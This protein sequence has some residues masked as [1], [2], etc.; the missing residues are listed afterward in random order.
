MQQI[1]LDTWSGKTCP[2]PSQ[3]TT[4]KD[5]RASPRRNGELPTPQY[6]FLDL[7]T[8]GQMLG[9]SWA[10]GFTISWRT[11]D[12]QYWGVPQRRRR[13]YLVADFGGQSA[14][15]IL[16]ESKA[17]WGYCGE[18]KQG[19]GIAEDAERC[20]VAQPTLINDISN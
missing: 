16:F 14:P 13:I 17:C 12:A 9:A 10:D 1:S 2:E 19:Q 3:Q 15:E 5:F 6:Q 8:A 11:V 4:E 18:R 7:S 20:V